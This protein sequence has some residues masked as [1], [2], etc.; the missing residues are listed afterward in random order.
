MW[1]HEVLIVWDY[2]ED[3]IL[4]KA[5]ANAIKDV[6]VKHWMVTIVQDWLIKVALWE[7]TTE[8]VLKLI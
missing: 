7:T 1:I 6:A 5:S 2:L 3:L 4:K 8:E